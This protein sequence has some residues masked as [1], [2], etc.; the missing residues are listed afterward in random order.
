MRWLDRRTYGKGEPLISQGEESD[1]IFF[2]ELGAVTVQLVLPGGRTVRLRTMGA[3]TIIGEIAVYLRLPRSATVVA[4]EETRWSASPARRWPDARG[5]PGAAAL[6][7]AFLARQLAEK[8][9]AATRQLAAAQ[10]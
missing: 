5:G 1:D 10:R 9:V 7:H 2:V 6:L 8:L 4:A 3:G